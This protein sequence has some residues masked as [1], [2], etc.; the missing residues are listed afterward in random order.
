MN[1]NIYY[2]DNKYV[3]PITQDTTTINIL[4]LLEKKLKTP[5]LQ[6][7][8]FHNKDGRKIFLK[9][10]D[11]LSSYKEKTIYLKKFGI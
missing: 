7:R 6:L 2:K 11:R 10:R 1:I 4:H 5:V 9:D 3:F 8:L